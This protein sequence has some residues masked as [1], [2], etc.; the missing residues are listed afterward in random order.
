MNRNLYQLDS[1]HIKTL[2][3]LNW[4]QKQGHFLLFD[5]LFDF[6]LDLTWEEG[7]IFSQE[8]PF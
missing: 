3:R 7:K 4:T 5:L 6:F 8:A 1:L 2:Y